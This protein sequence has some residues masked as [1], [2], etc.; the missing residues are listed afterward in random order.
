VPA[1]LG[2]HF[3]VDASA[4]RQIV[5]AAELAAGETVVEIGPGRGALTTELLA[6]GCRVVAIEMDRALA[7]LLRDQFASEDRIEIHEA[8]FLRF[9][10]EPYKAASPKF[11]GNLPYAAASP[12][13][14]KILSWA[15]WRLAVFMFQKEVADRLTARPGGADY[16]VLTLSRWIRADAEALMTLGPESFRPRPRVH[17]TVLR[18]R[19][20]DAPRLAPQEEEP[21]FRVAKAAFQERRKMAAG[22]MARLLNLPRSRLEAAFLKLGLDPRWRAQ[23]IPPEAY[24]KLPAEIGLHAA[25]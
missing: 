9:D 21:F 23:D 2:Q 3:L 20:L 22:A 6:R 19:R 17:S 4:A 1:K 10:I 11:L 14:Q 12:I 8:D 13:L 24:L 7:S 18:L 16:G 15:S 25:V 5:E